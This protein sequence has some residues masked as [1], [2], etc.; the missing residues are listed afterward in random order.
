MNSCFCGYLQNGGI[1]KKLQLSVL[2]RLLI[3]FLT[4]LFP[5][6]LAGAWIVYSSNEKLEKQITE[7]VQQ[8]TDKFTLLFNNQLTEINRATLAVIA[9]VRV[10]KLERIGRADA[11]YET[12]YNINIMREFMSNIQS[13]YAIIGNTRVYLPA[14]EIAC[15]SIGYKKGSIQS[16]SRKQY[17]DILAVKSSGSTLIFHENRLISLNALISQSPR[18][19]IEVEYNLSE[20]SEFLS[21]PLIYSDSC[22]FFHLPGQNFYLTNLDREK[23]EEIR[24][25]LQTDFK[26][27]SQ[28]SFSDDKNNPYSVFQSDIPLLSGTYIQFIPRRQL[29][30]PSIFSSRYVFLLLFFMLLGVLMFFGGAFHLIHKPLKKLSSAFK[31]LGEDK[32]FGIRVSNSESP[33]FAYLYSAFNKMSEQLYQLIVHDYSQSMLLQQAN[34]RQLQAQINPHFLYNSYFMLFRM[35]KSGQHEESK[36]VAKELGS[37][38]QY[39]TRSHSDTVT[40]KDEYTHAKIYSNIQ[41]VRF[42][43][44]IQVD[45]QE[46]PDCCGDYVVP[47]LILQ[48]IV[49]NA[50]NYGLENKVKN[51]LLKVCFLP[52]Q[53]DLVITVEEN[54]ESLTDETLEKIQASF[55]APGFD[56]L[57]SEITGLLNIFKRLQIFFKRD[58]VLS[59]SRSPLGGMCVRV[60]LYQMESEVLTNVSLVDRG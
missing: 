31:S 53:N 52:V 55:S 1:M 58:D 48:P 45:F 60:S 29:M 42:G 59:V 40:L 49:E 54:G 38:F 20:L 12:F 4:V 6:F 9:Q 41:A 19:I 15:N 46:L 32:N 3:L 34:F 21:S 27:V 35:I 14:L 5:L 18:S 50:F 33:D 16:L 17:L 47:K 10:A 8:N 36:T 44:R 26:Q 22:Y 51:G 23:A 30:Q 25:R 43:E 13:A 28:I 56:G 37:Y 7:S 2:V 57:T 11:D 24:I 39:I